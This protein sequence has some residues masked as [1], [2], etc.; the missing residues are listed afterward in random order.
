MNSVEV[1]MNN[2][3][4]LEISSYSKIN[5]K[6][7]KIDQNIT[8]K[9]ISDALMSSASSAGMEAASKILTESASTLSGKAESAGVD[10]LVK[11][12]GNNNAKAIGAGGGVSLIMML[13]ICGVFIALMVVAFILK[14]SFKKDLKD[15]AKIVKE[16]AND[17][18]VQQIFTGATTALKNGKNIGTGS[19]GLLHVQGGGYLRRRTT[20][21]WR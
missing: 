5:L 18:G 7:A 13:I 3:N 21:R 6:N 11:E 1:K 8:S 17:K 14:A 12:L 20:N 15:G 10:A 19:D 16:L 2:K 9:L 4:E